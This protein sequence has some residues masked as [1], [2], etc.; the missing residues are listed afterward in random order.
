MEKSYDFIFDKK[1]KT[2]RFSGGC[3]CSICKSSQ[4]VDGE[5]FKKYFIE[6][7]FSVREIK[8]FFLKSYSL[9]QKDNV[10]QILFI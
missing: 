3:D 4:A 7:D 8:L 5:I 6:I 2:G 1:W 9:K 10:T